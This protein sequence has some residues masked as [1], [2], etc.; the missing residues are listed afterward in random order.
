MRGQVTTDPVEVRA[1]NAALV[2]VMSTTLASCP[3]TADALP[4]LAPQVTTVPFVFR[5]AKAVSVA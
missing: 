5:A 3:L 1:A 2:A 4:P